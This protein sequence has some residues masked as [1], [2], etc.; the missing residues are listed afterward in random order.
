M[1]IK[2][3]TMPSFEGNT[4]F[5]RTESFKDPKREFNLP[6]SSVECCNLKSFQKMFLNVSCKVHVLVLIFV[7]NR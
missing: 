5:K 6:S 4:L 3:R 2:E 7:E 1:V